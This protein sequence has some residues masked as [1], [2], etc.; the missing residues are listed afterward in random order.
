MQNFSLDMIDDPAVFKVNVLPAHSDTVICGPDGHPLSLSLNGMWRFHYAENPASIVTGFEKPGMDVSG[1]KEIP[2]PSN[3]QMQG[4]DAPAY[5]NSQYPWDGRENLALGEAPKR[6]NP[7]AQYVTFFETPESWQGMEVRVRFHGVE[8]GFALWLNGTFVGYSE[9]S[10]TPSEFDLTP[11]LQEGVNRLAVLDFK[12]TNGSWLEDQ[13]MYRLSGIFRDVEL[14]PVA[15]AHVEDVRIK[16]DLDGA[17]SGGILDTEVKVSGQTQGAKLTWELLDRGVAKPDAVREIAFSGDECVAAGEVV[18]QKAEEG[19]FGRISAAAASI[20]AE[21]EQ[22]QPWSAEMPYLYELRLSLSAQDGSV[23]ET[24]AEYVGFRHFEMKDGIMCLNGRRI[25]FNGVNRHEFS[26]DTGRS[27][28]RED[29]EK[30]IR[31]MKRHNINAIRTCHYPNASIIY[32]LADLYGLYMIAETN[33]ETHGSWCFPACREEEKLPNDHQEYLPMML[34]RVRSQ[35]DRD[36]NHPAILI[37]SCGNESY[38]GQVIYQM[39]QHFKELDDTRLVHYEGVMHD[40]RYNDTSDMESQMYTSAADVE[41]FLEEHD[42][43]PFILCEY[44]HSMGNSNGGMHRYIELSERNPRYQG[45]F[46]WDFV[47]QAVRRKNRY[48]EE[49]LAYGGDCGERPTDYDFSGNGIID[50]TRRPYGKIQ[51]IKYNYRTIKAEVD[52]CQVK[53]TNKNLFVPTSVYD[54]VV[55]VEKEGKL[56]LRAGLDTDV[57]PLSRQVYDLPIAKE[58][59]FREE[60]EYAVTVSFLL[61]EDSL[62]EKKGYEVAFGQSV[63]TVGNVLPRSMTEMPRGMQDAAILGA[64]TLSADQTKRGASG[65]EV[66]EGKMN[67]GVRGEHFEVLFSAM[68]GGIVSYRFGGK[69]LIDEIPRPN[70]WRAPVSND[71]GNRMASRLGIWKIA[72]DYQEFSDPQKGIFDASPDEDGTYPKITRTEDYIE[73]IWKKF[74]PVLCPG[75]PLDGSNQGAGAPGGQ[76]MALGCVTCLTTYRVFADGTVRCILDYD[77]AYELPPMPEFGW[78]FAIS[79]DYDHVTYYGNG[80]EENYC[81]RKEGVKLGVYTRTV[82]DMMERYLVP[83]ETGNRTGVRWAKVTDR[84][85]HGVLVSAAGFPDS[86]DDQASI[87]GTMEFSALPYSPDQL[88]NA[89]HPYELPSVHKTWIRCSL[90]QMGVAG[91]DSWGARPHPEY[92]IPNTRRLVFAVDFKGI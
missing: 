55:Q 20:H 58:S 83:Q 34:D 9:D 41:R 21:L 1:W 75:K 25:V 46:I 49:Y 18:L 78:M 69:E 15:K 81:D 72:S 82:P 11:Y 43:K 74:L 88:E 14:Y 37:W 67:L 39:S 90:K 4:Y 17:F 80:P 33:M 62:W 84:S 23:L 85:G 28:R 16:A 59:I 92:M 57:A 27:P 68:K 22:V 35:Y 7:T 51:E 5:V 86:K 3:I 32:R 24:A 73:I 2:V 47:D 30:D 31:I 48:G 77:P 26:C 13:D 70:F 65:L 38:G 12:F 52:G 76:E 44:T 53:I 89:R 71:A 79:A 45:G 36:K 8:S 6:F 87:P 56:L 42:E 60:G 40:R 50:A 91:D 10:F 19:V 54:C 61:K 64:R 63:I 29:V 66:V